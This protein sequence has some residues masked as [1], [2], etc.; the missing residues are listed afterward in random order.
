MTA[1]NKGLTKESDPRVAKYA[2]SLVGHS[3]SREVRDTISKKN[4]GRKRTE[5]FKQR[6]REWSTKFNSMRGKHRTDKGQ[7]SEHRKGKGCGERNAMANPDNRK[8]VSERLKKVWER[9][10]REGDYVSWNKGLTKEKDSRVAK[11]AINTSIGICKSITSGKWIKTHPQRDT[12]PERKLQSALK[13]ANVLFITH[14]Y[15][16]F[17]R[18]YTEADIFVE[19]NI[20]V[21]VDGCYWHSCLQHFPN[22]SKRKR[23][24]DH[25]RS[26][27]LRKR[28]YIVIRF[29]EH[30]INDDVTKC[31]NQILTV[32]PRK[33]AI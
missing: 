22:G 26:D 6:N 8:M 9:K 13:Q 1:W 10:V 16:S 17:K 4:S 11:G 7:I 23:Y 29:W 2:Q 5:E 20:A 18:T 15:F 28:G 27:L 14:K 25:F 33:E 32:I 31:V 3:I 24:M 30:E 21:F 12:L 19:P